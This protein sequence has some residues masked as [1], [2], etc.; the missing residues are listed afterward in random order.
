MKPKLLAPAGSW[1][2]L[3][4]AVKSGADAVYLGVKGLNMRDSANN[5]D[6]SELKK[7][8]SYAHKNNAEVYLALNVIFFDDEI[9]KTKAILK[10]A[11]KAGIDAIICWDMGVIKLAKESGFKIHLSTQASASNI[12]A[13]RQYYNLGVTR[14]IIARECSLDKIRHIVK[15][16]KKISKNIEIEVF[17]H[18]AMCVALSG[19]CFMSHFLYDKSANRGKCIQPCRRSYIIKDPETFKELEVHNNYVLSP[20]D[21]CTLP[22]IEK[23]VNAGINTFKIEGRG[24]SP[25]Y[26]KVVTEVYRTALDK[27]L[28][29]NLKKE[30]MK[31]LKTVYNRGFSSGFYLGKPVNE[32]ADSYG[33]KSSK[34]KFY[35]G[36]IVKFYKKINVA[37]VKLESSGIK[38]KDNILVI[39]P[40]TG[41]IGQSVNSIHIDKGK[42]VKKAEKGQLVGIKLKQKA[43]VNDKVYIFR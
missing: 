29:D 16:A 40:T 35:I 13:I 23:L 1:E 33:S 3:V 4:A 34:K 10:Q 6:V 12:E 22:F 7:I 31:K 30:L 36:K 11:K 26:V 39:G 38:I 25:E 41:V 20:K 24:R 5:F 8:T 43:R 28:D 9:R 21:L 2:M 37:E 32:W 15:E 19:R 42:D 17:V 14:F 18:G 27:K